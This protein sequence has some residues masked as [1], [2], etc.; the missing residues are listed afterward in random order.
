MEHFI[1]ITLVFILGAV[2]GWGARERSAKKHVEDILTDL[3]SELKQPHD[4]S[5]INIVI[6]KHNNV[7][8]VYGNDNEF[9]GQGNDRLE[10]E[11]SLANRFPG[12]RFIAKTENLKDIG[13]GFKHESV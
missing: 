1:W 2:Y 4:D 13:W 3:E 12:K 8:Y 5:Y 11:Q 6:E 10:L 9:M 7:F